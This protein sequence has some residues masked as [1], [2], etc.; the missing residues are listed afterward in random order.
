MFFDLICFAFSGFFMKLSDEFMDRKE[1]KLMAIITGLLCVIFTILVSITNGDATCIFLSILIG[2]FL[3]GKVDTINHVL[4]AL[5][6]IAILLYVGVPS[7]GWYCL[8]ICIIAN[9]IDEKGN[10]KSDEIEEKENGKKG[11]LYNFF[12]YRSTLKV[13]V[14]IFSLLGLLKLLYPNSIL[15]GLLVFAPVTFIYMLAFDLSYE[16]ANLI[17]DRIYNFL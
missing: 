10:D 6:L 2:T 7:F 5:L 17:F 15:G 11:V 4:S 12:K 9:Y 1:N 13:V 3:A 14:L 16:F 8:L